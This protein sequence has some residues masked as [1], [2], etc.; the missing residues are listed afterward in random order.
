MDFLCDLNDLE[1]AV[2]TRLL[3]ALLKSIDELD[4]HC[5][6]LLACAPFAVVGT[7]DA[8]GTRRATAVGGPAGFT[9][10]DTPDRLRFPEVLPGAPGTA[11]STMFLIPGWREALRI[12]GHV[13]VD[14]PAVLV[15]GEAFVHCGKAVLRSD[16]WA[17]PRPRPAQGDGVDGPL[18]PDVRAFLAASPFVVMTSYDG[19]GGA[20]ASPKGDAPGFIEVLDDATVAIPDRRGNR[21]TDTFHNIIEDPAVAVL[22]LVPGDDRVLEL[23]GRARITD[24]ETL[25]D[26]MAVDGKV[27]RAALVLDIESSALA[28]SP[29]IRAARL[30]DPTAR[31]D[32][33]H[34][35][36]AGQMWADHVKA[37]GTTGMKAAAIRA[38]VNGTAIQAGTEVDYKRGLY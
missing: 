18:G 23:R 14:D 2:G 26:A 30:W 33:D 15:V 21:R 6:S 8:D 24:D 17:E 19:V 32:L 4:D 27:P 3:P 22:V 35:P 16:L 28:V 25:R 1:R 38:A 12:N 11:A 31:V 29:A 5:A 37:N 9:S 20:D 34:L 13:D 36:K 10:I 7:Q